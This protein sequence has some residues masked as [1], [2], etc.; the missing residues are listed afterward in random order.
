MSGRGKGGKVKGKS[1]SRSDFSYPLAI[2]GTMDITDKKP[3]RNI[4]DNKPNQINNQKIGQINQ[5]CQKI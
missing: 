4:S 2:I 1:K 3:N 5:Q